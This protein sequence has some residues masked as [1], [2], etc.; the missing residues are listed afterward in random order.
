MPNY[1][2]DNVNIYPDDSNGKDSNYSNKNI[3]LNKWDDL[4]SIKTSIFFVKRYFLRYSGK[5]VY[6]SVGPAVAQIIKNFYTLDFYNFL[7]SYSMGDFSILRLGQE[8]FRN[9]GRTISWINIINFI[10]FS[11]LRV[12]SSIPWNISFCK[13]PFL[14]KIFLEKYK[15][16]F[17]SSIFIFLASSQVA[18]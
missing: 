7:S 13:V 5:F 18:L 14:K 16:L 11:G 9:M 6:L 2:T 12:K 17:Q 4:A 10:S 8:P 15:K 3:L 1:I